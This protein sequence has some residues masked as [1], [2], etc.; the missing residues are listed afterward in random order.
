VQGVR[1]AAA[2]AAHGIPRAAVV[3]AGLRVRV[4]DPVAAALAAALEGVV[5]AEVV[6]QFV[7]QGVAKVEV[8]AGAPRQ[9][10][11]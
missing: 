1:G 3:G 8:A 9:R 10:T 11:R 6:P 4:V 5:E 7:G 2:R